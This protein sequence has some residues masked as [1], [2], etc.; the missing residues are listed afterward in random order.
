MKVEPKLIIWAI[1]FCFQIAICQGQNWEPPKGNK[2]FSKVEN[3]KTGALLTGLRND[4]LF[5]LF[6]DRLLK[7]EFY[8]AI[9][10]L[11]CDSCTFF[12]ET[13][14]FRL[15]SGN[16][17]SKLQ[18]TLENNG[19]TLF[20]IEQKTHHRHQALSEDRRYEDLCVLKRYVFY[21]KKK[22]IYRIDYAAKKNPSDCAK[23][24]WQYIEGDFIYTFG[25]K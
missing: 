23:L 18:S 15:N 22:G 5:V 3:I 2:F 17:D 4:T 19:D 20:V 6:Y 14:N 11:S 9:A 21:S 7:V 8:S 12:E 10:D 1:F 16:L 25:L 24:G 13:Y